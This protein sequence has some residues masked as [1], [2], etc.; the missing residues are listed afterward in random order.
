MPRLGLSGATNGGFLNRRTQPTGPRYTVKRANGTNQV[1]DN[2][3]YG[4]VDAKPT[5][6]A[7]QV[8]ADQLN[9]RHA[10]GQP[11]VRR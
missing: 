4:V 6:Q 3:Y 8:R 1:F 11:K 7:A 5:P 2:V 9:E 10:S